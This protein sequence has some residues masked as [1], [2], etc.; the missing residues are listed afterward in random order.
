MKQR[1][2]ERKV[3]IWVKSFFGRKI[4]TVAENDT[5]LL[6]SVTVALMELPCNHDRCRRTCDMHG[7]SSKH[8]LE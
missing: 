3:E 8:Q 5:V 7:S 4:A 1:W 2:L 6:C